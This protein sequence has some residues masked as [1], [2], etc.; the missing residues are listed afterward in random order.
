MY[1]DKIQVFKGETKAELACI[2][3]HVKPP[4]TQAAEVERR[5]E[6][7]KSTKVHTF[8]ANL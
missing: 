6:E 4:L 5:E 7:R 1:F 2:L 3:V 8:S